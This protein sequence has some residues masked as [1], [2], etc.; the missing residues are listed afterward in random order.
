M[1]DDIVKKIT[2][3]NITSLFIIQIIFG[4]NQYGK[5]NY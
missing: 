2:I 4:G 1:Q 3:S 5:R